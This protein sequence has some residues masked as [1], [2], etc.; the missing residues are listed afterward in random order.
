MRKFVV[1]G[2]LLAVAAGLALPLASGGVRAEDSETLFPPEMLKTAPALTAAVHAAPPIPTLT[3]SPAEPS[4]PIAAL[5]TDAV[6]TGVDPT[7][8]ASSKVVAATK[9]VTSAATP[10]ARRHAHV[11]ADAPRRHYRIVRHA[12]RRPVLYPVQTARV[13]VPPQRLAQT[14]PTAVVTAHCAGFCGNYVLVGVGF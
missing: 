9:N 10:V 11:V 2:L 14:Q 13:P 7:V 12:H 5:A 4:P 6:S 1:P 3:A 8:V